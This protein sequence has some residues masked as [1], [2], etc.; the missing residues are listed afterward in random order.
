MWNEISCTKLQLPP[1]PL[2][3]GLP[4]PDPCSLCPLSSTEFVEP[5][6][7][8][9]FLGTPLVC[10]LTAVCRGNKVCRNACSAFPLCIM[11]RWYFRRVSRNLRQVRVHCIWIQ[12][13]LAWPLLAEQY[14]LQRGISHWILR[15][16]PSYSRGALCRLWLHYVGDGRSVLGWVICIRN[17]FLKL[18]WPLFSLGYSNIWILS[19]NISFSGRVRWRRY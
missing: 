15:V 2:T 5:P 6:P 4:P 16:Y 11:G 18:T 1:E 19:K 14:S 9:K 13:S 3:R 8:T 10:A 17:F 7:R 12:A